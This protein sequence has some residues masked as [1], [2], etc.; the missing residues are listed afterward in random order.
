MTTLETLTA[1]KNIVVHGGACPDGIASAMILHDALP[2]AEI[3][4]V[5]YQTPEQASLEPK[6]NMLFCDITPVAERAADFV[7]AGAVVLDHHKTAKPVVEAFGPMGAFGDEKDDPGVCGA[8]LAYRHVWMP[9]MAA[10]GGPAR[11]VG[12][13]RVFDF[14]TLAGIRDTWLNKH[15]RWREAVVQ[16]EMLRFYPLEHWMGMRAAFSEAQV[17]VWAERRKLGEVVVA[18][19]E[20]SVKRALEKVWRFTTAKGTRV[21][22]F[23]GTHLSS[24]AA[25]VIDK[26][27]DIVIGFGFVVEGGEQKQ[28]FSMRSH[29]GY[30]VAVLCKSFGGGGHTAAAGFNQVISGRSINPYE[31]AELLVNEHE[32]NTQK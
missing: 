6:P 2:D 4:F 12:A 28:I 11:D 17:P 26:E 9:V 16:A 7:A 8:V 22:M 13:A 32:A 19:H 27:A 24:D 1:V 14:A 29:T 15:P 3:R 31:F 30:D 23:E 20:A 21:I 25:E 18:R 5:Q 10:R